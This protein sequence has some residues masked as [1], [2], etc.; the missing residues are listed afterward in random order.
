MLAG[1]SFTGQMFISLLAMLGGAFVR[2]HM[3][4]GRTI[5]RWRFA[6]FALYLFSAVYSSLWLGGFL[7]VE[8]DVRRC[9]R[10]Y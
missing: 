3:P 1:D 6:L 5:M 9:G 4:V 2:E 10:D 7:V 8:P